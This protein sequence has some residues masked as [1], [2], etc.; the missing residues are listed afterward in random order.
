MNHRPDIYKRSGWCGRALNWAACRCGRSRRVAILI[1]AIVL[2]SLGDLYM[3]TT[4]LLSG[5]F[6]E[7][8]PLAR[9]VMSYNSP[10][11][12]ATWKMATVF[13]ATGILF[14][15]RRRPSA[16]LAAWFCCLLLAW[17]TVRWVAY[18]EH[19]PQLTRYV[20]RD[21]IP[22]DRWVSIDALQ[23]AVAETP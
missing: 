3:T 20:A 6:I 18:A 16:E 14:A 11:M 1:G 4:F 10:A 5:G 17:V 7:N 8:N 23:T 9:N 21:Q 15:F 19:A 13:L 2:L 22:D 12:L